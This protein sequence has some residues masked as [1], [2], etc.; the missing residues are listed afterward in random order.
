MVFK[1]KEAAPVES[2]EADDIASPKPKKAKEAKKPGPKLIPNNL[3]AAP[4][5]HNSGQKNPVVVE[6]LK[7]MLDSKD[8]QKNEAK[9]QR[10]CR[11]RLKTEFGI[12]SSVTAYGLKMLSLDADVRI[13]FESGV[14]DMRVMTGYQLALDLRKETIARTE[15]EYVD[16]ANK[17]TADTIQ[18]EG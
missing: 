6:I 16:P 9:L 14:A 12:L 8:R 4:V 3:T 15:E 1:R 18:R 10:D 5:G 2:G 7:E 11:N 17:V 13:Q